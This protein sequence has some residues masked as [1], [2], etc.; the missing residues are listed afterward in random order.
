MEKYQD[1]QAIIMVMATS[2]TYTRLQICLEIETL[3]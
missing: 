1:D 3:L 2:T